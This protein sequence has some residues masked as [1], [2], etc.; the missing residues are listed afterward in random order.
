VS[1]QKRLSVIL[2]VILALI[3]SSY[4]I[5]NVFRSRIRAATIATE[6]VSI[7]TEKQLH[8]TTVNSAQTA[9]VEYWVSP[10]NLQEY[11]LPF[12]DSPLLG[13]D[14]NRLDGKAYLQVRVIYAINKDIVFLGGSLFFPSKGDANRS[15]LLRSVDGGKHWTEVMQTAVVSDVDR[16]VFLG[17]GEGWALVI[18]TGESGS[19]MP[20][21]LW[22]TANFG[23]TW[24][25]AGRVSPGSPG[26]LGKY[27]TL[28]FYSS[29]HGEIGF[30]CDAFG[31]CE[32]GSYYSIRSTEDG[33]VTWQESYHLALPLVEGD[34]THENRLAAFILPKGGLY[35]SHI[36][37]C[38]YG[39]IQECP[40]YGQDGSKWQAEYS[41]DLT[42]LFVRRHLP[43]ESEWATFIL[44]ACVEYRQGKIIESCSK[45]P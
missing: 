1:N 7:P 29:T 25:I 42:N 8:P 43:F 26:A 33:G 10:A 45:S 40:S 37:N 38:W 28:K 35:G 3:A 16:I 36:G 31:Q 32:E 14:E 23:E 34:P 22:H 30:L 5:L 9:T 44:S 4:G 21:M 24:D 41:E 17:Q 18:G 19:I 15:V 13:F 12:L 6:S 27:M 39:N 20:T 2:V 11:L